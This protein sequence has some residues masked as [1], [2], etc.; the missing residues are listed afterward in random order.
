MRN[1]GRMD[2]AMSAGVVSHMRLRMILAGLAW[3]DRLVRHGDP[4]QLCSSG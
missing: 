3:G 2:T 4:L 1:Y